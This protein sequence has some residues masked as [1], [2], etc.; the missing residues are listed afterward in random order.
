VVIVSQVAES[1]SKA[2]RITHLLQAYFHQDC[3]VDDP[4]WEAIVQRFKTMESPVTVAAT[5][6]ALLELLQTRGDQEIETLV[7]RDSFFTPSS[8]GLSARTWIECV[9]HILAGGEGFQPVEHSG[10]RAAAVAIAER[11]LRG[12]LDFVTGARLLVD[13]RGSVGVPS[14][15]PDLLTFIGIDS[16]TDALPI[17]PVRERWA[18]E[19]LAE[20]AD[21]ID[22]AQRWAREY[23]EDA[24]RN[25]ISRFGQRR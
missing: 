9:V 3:F 20:K 19:A 15:D 21:A 11:V 17:G 24:F 6:E 12:E 1:T 23:G 14:D 22:R 7:A 2:E 16:E 13:L 5:R 4:T 18:P 10:S 25:L 8:M